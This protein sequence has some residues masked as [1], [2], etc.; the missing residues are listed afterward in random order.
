VND[1]NVL[2]RKKEV[3]ARLIERAGSV[4]VAFSGGL[5]S[6]FLLA[7]AH[8]VLGPR[9]VAATAVSAIH[10]DCE[11]EAAKGFARERGIEHIL[12]PSKELGLETFLANRP[13]RCYH[14]KQALFKQMVAAAKDMAVAAVAH[15]ANADDAKDFRPGMRA[16][17]EAGVWAPLVEA[18]LGKGE[19]RLL[20]KAMGLPTWD[21]P[22]NACLATRIPYGSP[23]TLEK[24]DMIEK[25]E[26][27]LVGKGI[28]QC[29]VRHHGSV[30]RIELERTGLGRIME[31]GLREAVVGRF[32]EIGFVHI[33]LDLEEYESGRMNRGLVEVEVKEI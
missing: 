5:D 21:K 6:A 7:A 23:I 18:G 32:R 31:G 27:F 29:R 33:A 26:A 20:S 28:R 10:P 17:Q 14:C 3:L 15:G 25:A 16:A 13:D 2:E 30:A 1:R 9:V 11:K 12:I 19:I 8:E 24:L 22:S 4:L